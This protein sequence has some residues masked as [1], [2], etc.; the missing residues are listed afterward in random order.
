MKK[1]FKTETLKR[2]A[3]LNPPISNKTK[4]TLPESGVLASAVL[5]SQTDSSFLASAKTHWYF[6]EWEWLANI[7]LDLFTE[8]HDL[9]KLALLKAAGFQQL[10]DVQNCETFIRIAKRKGCDD[11]SIANVLIAGAHNSLGRISALQQQSDKMQKHF[12]HAVEI[13]EKTKDTK[14]AIKARTIKEL[15]SLGLLK[16][17]ETELE[18]QVSLYAKTKHNDKQQAA[19]LNLIRKQQAELKIATQVNYLRPTAPRGNKLILIASMPRSGSTWLFNCSRMIL[20]RAGQYFYSCWEADYDS[21]NSAKIHLV[22]VHDP[23]PE[24]SEKADIVISTRRDIRA[25]A[26]SL[27]RM[28][29]A[30]QGEEF[31]NQLNWVINTVHPFW[32]E[33]S[34][35]EIEYNQIIKTPAIV[36]EGIAR[37]LGFPIN[38]NDAK[39]IAIKLEQMQANKEYDKTTQLHP[40]HRAEN[41]RHYSEYLPQETLSIINSLFYNWLNSYNYN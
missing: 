11:K 15:T 36:A 14:L 33:R 1:P 17:A 9:P 3:E 29:W 21:N 28:K 35:L 8:H 2:Q 31:I 18:S 13:S 20:E 6:G 34:D 22:K 39:L 25:V 41:E 30:N 24:L 12:S 7:D 32:F 5:V 37:T 23:I 16:D 27:I 26:A 4:G 40:N 19:L 38:A 10:G